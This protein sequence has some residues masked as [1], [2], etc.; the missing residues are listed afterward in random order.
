M[1]WTPSSKVSPTARASTVNF[2]LAL[3]SEIKENPKCVSVCL[4]RRFFKRMELIGT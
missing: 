4:F 2:I 1:A 3:G